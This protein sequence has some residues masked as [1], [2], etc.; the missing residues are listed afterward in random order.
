MATLQVSLK[1]QQKQKQ[2]GKEKRPERSRRKCGKLTNSFLNMLHQTNLSK[3]KKKFLV[4]T[5]KK[6]SKYLSGVAPKFRCL[7]A[8]RAAQ[9]QWHRRQLGQVSLFSIFGDIPFA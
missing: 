7:H 8:Q 3:P 5:N 4:H 6:K 9:N 1:Q 2:H